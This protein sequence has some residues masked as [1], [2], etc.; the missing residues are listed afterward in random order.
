MLTCVALAFVPAA[1]ADSVTLAPAADNTL[2]ENTAGATSDGAGATMFVGRTNQASNFR[3]RGLVRFDVASAV[4]AG[5]TIQSVTLT[6]SMSQAAS[7]ANQPVEL[8][9]VLASWGEGASDAGISGGT[10]APSAPGDA[11]WK[12]RSFAGTLWAALGGDFA[13][14][15]TATLA[16]GAEGSY[17]WAS[18]PALV[19][20]VQGWLDTPA[21]NFGW[22]LLGNE[23]AAAT[24]KRFDTREAADPASR[25]ALTIAYEAPATAAAG[26]TWGRIKGLYR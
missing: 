10:G 20:E 22:L 7:P 11:T 25:P 14:A 15:A 13:P 21:A 3:R 5:S 2:F 12:H 26:T 16:V 24:T 1:F 23:A 17:T 9:T 19:A 4:P 8:R 18:S 6:L